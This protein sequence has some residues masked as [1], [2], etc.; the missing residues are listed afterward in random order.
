MSRSSVPRF[1]VKAIL[2]GG[3]TAG[4]CDG[5]YAVLYYGLTRGISAARIFQSVASG[6]LGPA[7]FSMGSTSVIIGLLCHFTIALGAATVYCLLASRFR[8]LLRSATLCGPVFGVGL[9][10]FMNYVVIPL[11]AVP[12]SP[13]PKSPDVVVTGLLVHAFL[14]GL[15]IAAFARSFLWSNAVRVAVSAPRAGDGLAT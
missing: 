10:L 15:P 8:G 4:L 9:Y 5:T 1:R 2:F 11:S 13:G 7:S 14:I 3:L 6:L 12:R